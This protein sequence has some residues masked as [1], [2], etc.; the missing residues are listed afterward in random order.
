MLVLARLPRIWNID[1][2]QSSLHAR[3]IQESVDILIRGRI[4]CI[5]LFPVA[6]K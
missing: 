4:K 6:E 5:N 1:D 2:V 3:I